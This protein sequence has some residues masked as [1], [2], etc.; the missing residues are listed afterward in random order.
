M[1]NKQRCDDVHGCLVD[2]DLFTLVF[3]KIKHFSLFFKNMGYDLKFDE[4]GDFYFTQDLRDSNN[5]ESDDNEMKI[6]SILLFI[7]RYY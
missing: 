6:Q 3:N 4:E 2:D 1:L 5:D 7:E